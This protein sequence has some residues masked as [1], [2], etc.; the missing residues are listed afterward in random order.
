MK[1]GRYESKNQHH[2]YVPD[3]RLSMRSRSSGQEAYQQENFVQPV[4]KLQHVIIRRTHIQWGTWTKIIPYRVNVLHCIHSN[5]IGRQRFNIRQIVGKPDKMP[6][7]RAN[8]S[9]LLGEYSKKGVTP[10]M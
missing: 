10:E 5:G 2:V 3:A 9:T 1:I 8:V 6:A 4:S 7:F